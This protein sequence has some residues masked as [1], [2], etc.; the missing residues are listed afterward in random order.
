MARKL[1]FRAMPLT[2]CF[3]SLALGLW[4]SSLSAEVLAAANTP[5][6]LPTQ[7]L[8]QDPEKEKEAKRFVV[9]EKLMNAR[10]ETGTLLAGWLSSK[11]VHEE[12]RIR[13]LEVSDQQYRLVVK[14]GK[15]AKSL[16]L[17]L[18]T[19]ELRWL[20]L[21]EPEYAK[22]Q[23]TQQRCEQALRHADQVILKGILT[24]AQGARLQQIRWQSDPEGALA[25]DKDL[26][27]SL[28]MTNEQIEEV[29]VRWKFARRS[30]S[31]PPPEIDNLYVTVGKSGDPVIR[32][33]YRKLLIR[34]AKE[35]KSKVYEV[36]TPGQLDRFRTLMG[37]RWSGSRFEF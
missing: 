16:R 26:H 24:P 36:L 28:K 12:L 23:E 29:R 3:A 7:T 27:K 25:D 15:L 19:Q 2:L 18:M 11:A 33:E 4:L 37:P 34:H 6:I 30:I 5:Q 8:T 22:Q 17:R 32:E 10:M 31:R 13:G 9:R 35:M 20:E 1:L 21:D 14:T